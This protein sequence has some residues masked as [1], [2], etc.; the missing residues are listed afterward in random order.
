MELESCWYRQNA[1]VF[2]MLTECCIGIK[3]QGFLGGYVNICV[4]EGGRNVS[5]EQS[6]GAE[7]KEV[8]SKDVKLC[9]RR[10]AHKGKVLSKRGEANGS[11]K[12][13]ACNFLPFRG[14]RRG[15]RKGQ[16]GK[17]GMG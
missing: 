6:G 11:K 5:K 1:W 15:K 17:R 14:A 10:P 16:E 2:V 3:R 8:C 7:K 12:V 13:K 4:R 9:P